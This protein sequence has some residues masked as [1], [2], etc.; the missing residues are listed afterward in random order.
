MT[1]QAAPREKPFLKPGN[2]V[3]TTTTFAPVKVVRV[4]DDRFEYEEKSNRTYM[5][6]ASDA[7]RRVPEECG[8]L[9]DHMEF[10]E[11]PTLYLALECFGDEV[12]GRIGAKIYSLE[13]LNNGDVY[14]RI[15][16]DHKGCRYTFEDDSFKKSSLP[17]DQ[18]MLK[19]FLQAMPW[20][21]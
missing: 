20:A 15:S 4:I 7:L 10:L 1:V 17:V 9:H 18:W 5:A 16:K 2:R 12:F 21:R 6:L 13:V 3:L 14:A 8:G 19:E 11:N